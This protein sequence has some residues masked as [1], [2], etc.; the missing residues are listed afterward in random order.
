MTNEPPRTV[1]SEPNQ[2]AITCT[3]RPR[4]GMNI[5][6]GRNLISLSSSEANR[7][8]H[9]INA[10]RIAHRDGTGFYKDR[11]KV[12]ESEPRYQA[13]RRESELVHTTET[14]R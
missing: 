12:T 11:R 8:K 7:L 13:R 6:Q 10:Y 3:P 14:P 9:T 4:G 2:P 1:V 5:Q